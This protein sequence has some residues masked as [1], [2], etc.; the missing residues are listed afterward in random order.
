MI[1]EN[2]EVKLAQRL[3]STV[4]SQQ[5]GGRGGPGRPLCAASRGL[6]EAS[7]ATR[8]L[9]LWA[10][11]FWTQPPGL[12]ARLLELSLTPSPTT[13]RR[14]L[15]AMGDLLSVSGLLGSHTR[16]PISSSSP[17]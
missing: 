5:P 12:L 6:A 17:P 16:Q 8:S 3:P 13:L 11:Y 14:P 9:W 1:H 4:C 10:F 15:H 2:Q 7:L